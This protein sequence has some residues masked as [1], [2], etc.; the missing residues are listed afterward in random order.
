MEYRIG[1]YIAVQE[2][3][4]GNVYVTRPSML[5]NQIHTVKINA[6]AE[7]IAKW[8]AAR[9]NGLRPPLVQDAFPQLNDAEREFLM[10]GITDEEW[11][12]SVVGV[13]E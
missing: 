7:A 8:L 1:D 5:S 12:V 9:I 13:D 2:D 6:P 3:A 11:T 10:T 4:A